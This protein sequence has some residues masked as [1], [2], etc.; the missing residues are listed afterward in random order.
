MV[1]LG[2]QLDRNVL[3]SGV[4]RTGGVLP[5]G[6]REISF[7]RDG[8]T[9]T[10]TVART[11][12]SN[13]LTLA[14]NGKPDASL[15]PAWYQRCDSGSRPSPLMADAA[16]QALLPLVTLAHM[17]GAT[18]AAVIGQGSGMSSHLLLGSSALKDLVTIEIEPQMIEGSKL[19]LPANRR[20]F[21][22]PRSEIVID[23]AKSYFASAQRRFDLIMSEPS[24][25][26]VSGV[27]GLFTTEFYGRVRQYLTDDGVFGQ[28]LH[29]YELDDGLVLSVLAAIHQNFRS[30]EVYLVP[31]GDL[32]VVA[33]NRDTLPTPDWSVFQAAGVRSDLCHFAPLTPPVLDALS[34]V[35]RAELAP[36]VETLG[37]PNSD[38][39]P[40]LDLGAERR[41]F[42]Q[43]HAS[44][45]PALADEWYNLFASLSG[46]RTAPGGEPLP[47]LPE[48]PR[49]R[50]RAL[51]ALVR[52]PEAQVALDSLLGP[53]AHQAIYLSNA[54]QALLTA[55]RAPSNWELW[56]EQ[57]NGVD[58]LRNGGTA[59]IADEQFYG[60]LVKF[61]DRHRAPG[62]ARDVVAFRRALAGWNFAEAAAAADRLMPVVLAEHRW[63][64]PD[65][66][67]DGLVMARLHLRDAAGARQAL[68]TLAKFSSRPA[69]DLR[70]MLLGAY[71]QTLESMQTAASQPLG[72][73]P[74]TP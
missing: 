55:D 71:V 12:K 26:W 18:S 50:A 52:S 8:R 44:G 28:W 61:M 38:Y 21:D 59:G 29:V 31:S 45:F 51:G 66:L 37:Q 32:L 65:E 14:T 17:P 70:S 20:T 11:V 35:S 13:I 41:R 7:Y 9:A 56:L 42:R 40:V 16:T 62:T 46:R 27:S 60:A 68:D 69:G 58:R 49:V 19:F 53:V 1:A 39:Y 48:N 10:V 34:L 67:R 47:A 54:W 23:D 74:A 30:Y 6:E 73:T 63:I 2:V 25:P 33:S 36:L 57:A 72:A 15:T 43:D 3:S 4:Y 64:S 22:D 24:N 5:A